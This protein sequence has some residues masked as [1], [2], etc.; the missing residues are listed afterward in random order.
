[1]HDTT[2]APLVTYLALVAFGRTF[3]KG[4]EKELINTECLRFDVKRYI[5]PRSDVLHFPTYRIKDRLILF[6][7][8][9][10]Q[11][12]CEHALGEQKLVASLQQ[13]TTTSSEGDPWH[14]NI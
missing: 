1:M 9:G 11:V 6:E 12:G 8:V 10:I 5:C 14:R 3:V 2:R 7:C 4:P 13:F